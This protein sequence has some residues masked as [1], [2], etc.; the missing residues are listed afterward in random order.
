MNSVLTR[1]RGTCRQSLVTMMAI[2]MLLLGTGQESVFWTPKTVGGYASLPEI[3][4]T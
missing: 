4:S 3:W 2:G 1:M